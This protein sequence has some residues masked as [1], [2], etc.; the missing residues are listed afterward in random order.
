MTHVSFLKCH[1]YDFSLCWIDRYESNNGVVL[2]WAPNGQGSHGTEHGICYIS[3]DDIGVC[4]G[5]DRDMVVR[6]AEPLFKAML[7]M[8][9]NGLQ[10]GLERG[11]A[12]AQGRI[13]AAL[14]APLPKIGVPNA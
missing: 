13:H 2:H 8:H 9:N 7:K 1:M 6:R 10:K 4:P 3:G 11:C 5:D 12:E 14:N